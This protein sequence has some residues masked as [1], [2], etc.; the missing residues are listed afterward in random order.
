MFIPS[1]PCHGN[2]TGFF[3]N[4]VFVI[5]MLLRKT[6]SEGVVLNTNMSGCCFILFC[7]TQ[8]L[9]SLAENDNQMIL[10][11][12][13]HVIEGKSVSKKNLIFGWKTYEV[14]LGLW[15]IIFLVRVKTYSLFQDGTWSYTCNGWRTIRWKGKKIGFNH[16]P[17][18]ENYSWSAKCNSRPGKLYLVTTFCHDL[19]SF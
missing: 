12:I 14:R 5:K 7:T 6:W 16:I 1:R 10:Y 4:N 18:H 11:L 8:D 13:G 19:L 9:I 2:L 3:T 15:N 17:T